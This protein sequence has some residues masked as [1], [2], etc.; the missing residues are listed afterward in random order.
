MNRTQCSSKWQPVG[1][2]IELLLAGRCPDTANP[3]LSQSD[4]DK[5]VHAREVPEKVKR[6]KAKSVL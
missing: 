4:L 6:L 2:A 3:P 5:A 1:K